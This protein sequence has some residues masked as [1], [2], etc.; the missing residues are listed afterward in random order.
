MCYQHTTA[1]RRQLYT[2]AVDWWM[3]GS[4]PIHQSV[5]RS[6][7]DGAACTTVLQQHRIDLANAQTRYNG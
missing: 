2:S 7:K 5:M 3:S 6:L 1:S 4:V